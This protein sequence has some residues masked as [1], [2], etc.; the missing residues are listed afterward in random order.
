MAI[1]HVLEV[2][3]D[4]KNVLRERVFRVTTSLCGNTL[5]CWRSYW[6]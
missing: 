6:M 5:Q 4:H 1:S 2:F 3:K